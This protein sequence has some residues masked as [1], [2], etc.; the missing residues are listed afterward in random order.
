MAELFKSI[1]DINERHFHLLHGIRM[2]ILTMILSLV[3]AIATAKL[4]LLAVP[5]AGALLVTVMILFVGYK[6]WWNLVVF[7]LFGYMF[8]SR[9]FA[10]IGFNP[11]FIGEITLALGVLTLLLLPFSNRIRIVSWRRLY[12]P[13]VILIILIIGWNLFRTLPYISAYKFDAL[14]DAVLYGYAIYAVLIVLLVRK[15]D[16]D[17]F[18]RWFGLLIPFALVWSLPLFFNSRMNLIPLAFPGSPF[19]FIYSKGTD[20]GVHL[21]GIVAFMLLQLDQVHQPRARWLIWFNWIMWALSTVFHGSAGRA[22]LLCNGVSAGV[23][24]LLRPLQ[25]R[26]DRPV[27]LG[28][29]VICIMLMT[30]TYTAKIELG[31]DRDISAEQLVANV[32]SIFSEGDDSQGS[33]EGTK[34]WRLDWWDKIM[35]YTFNG[36]Y[37][38]TGKGYGVN[39]ANSDGFQVLE[40]ESLR[41]PHNG[42]MTFLARGGVPGFALWVALLVVVHLR[43]LRYALVKW[44]SEPIKA[45]YAVWF[46]AYL[47]AHALV[48][49]FDVFLEG[50]MAGIW[51][52]SLVG[53]SVA[54]FTNEDTKHDPVALRKKA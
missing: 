12:Q 26:W 31:N 17:G 24:F 19:P 10:S 1:Q 8:F 3:G 41:S 14:R 25:S 29:L 50:P 5:V 22:L 38:W 9:G 47:L 16:I 33:L 54:Y 39:L 52:W 36:P 13:E 27:L 45:R 46:L 20:T 7:I 15:E 11:L 43:L 34:Q 2:A 42:H 48:T 49:S 53:M 37:F 28:I 18:I 23:V 32:I 30:D 44:T 21:A 6:L 4:G 51:F 40:D 35:D